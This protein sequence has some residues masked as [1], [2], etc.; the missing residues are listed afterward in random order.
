MQLNSGI[1]GGGM[2]QKHIPTKFELQQQE[3]IAEILDGLIGA[4][5]YIEG[6][7][8]HSPTPETDEMTVNELTKI[9]DKAMKPIRDNT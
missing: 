2:V 3:L 1:Q 7:I 5:N 4:R 6:F 9:I 8:E